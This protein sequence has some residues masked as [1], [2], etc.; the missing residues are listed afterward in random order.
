MPLR[1]YRLGQRRGGLDREI[2]HGG[3]ADDEYVPSGLFTVSRLWVSGMPEPDHVAQDNG[4]Q[5]RHYEMEI[6]PECIGHRH[7]NPRKQYYYARAR[8]A[9]AREACDNNSA[10]HEPPGTIAVSQHGRLPRCTAGLNV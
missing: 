6:A 9:P 3:D 1:A 7:S 5:D 2:N 10:Q 4:C 8:R